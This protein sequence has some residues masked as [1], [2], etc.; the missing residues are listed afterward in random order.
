M[1]QVGPAHPLSQMQFW[2]LSQ[3]P[4]KLH[5]AEQ[6]LDILQKKK[7]QTNT[8]NYCQQKKIGRGW[9]AKH[10]KCWACN[11]SPN[12]AQNPSWVCFS[13]AL[14]Q[15][16]TG[17]HLTTILYVLYYYIVYLNFILLLLLL[18][19][20]LLFTLF[21]FVKSVTQRGHASSP[22]CS[23][24]NYFLVDRSNW[25]KNKKP[26]GDQWKNPHDLLMMCGCYKSKLYSSSHFLT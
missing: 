12:P 7:L 13:L 2:S 19:L 24:D 6:S 11:R 22:D 4:W 17:V 18:L 16:V 15:I 10:S 23:Q 14:T 5:F 1:L 9:V 3:W 8:K 25:L 20:L 26:F 21:Y